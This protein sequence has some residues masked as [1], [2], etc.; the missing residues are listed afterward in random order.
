MKEDF[1]HHLWKY[2]L[3]NRHN[4]KTTDGET[5]EVIHAGQHNT[6]AG[7]DFFN[8]KVKVGETLWAGNVEIHLKSSDWKKH[9][10]V[11]SDKQ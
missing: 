8:A 11:S 10:P 3:Y 4:L 9:S 6:N 1:L 7:P 2:K 5:V